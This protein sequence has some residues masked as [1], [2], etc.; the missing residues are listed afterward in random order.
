MTYAAYLRIYEPVAAFHEAA[1]LARRRAR[2]GP[3]AGYHGPPDRG[4]GSGERARLY[5]S[6]GRRHLCL[7][8][9]DQANGIRDPGAAVHHTDIPGPAA[10]GPRPGGAAQ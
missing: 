7:S 6:R 8:V 2:R 10:R 4:A 3:A 1:R 9:A 5:T